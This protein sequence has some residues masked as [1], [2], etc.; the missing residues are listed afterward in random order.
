MEILTFVEQLKSKP[1]RQSYFSQELPTFI[2]KIKNDC[3]W[4]MGDLKSIIMINEPDMQVVLTG[5]HPNTEI[6][7]ST[8]TYATVF[9]VIEGA[10]KVSVN[11]N[12]TMLIDNQKFTL[13][14]KTK[15]K[16]EAVSQTFFLI[17]QYLES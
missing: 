9:H 8:T 16:L 6:D 5:L 12:S 10:L 14:I 2:N 13:N 1:L 4:K 3:G 15:Y 17:V 11:K 7:S